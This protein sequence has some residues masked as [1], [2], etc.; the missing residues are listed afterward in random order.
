MSNPVPTQNIKRR[1]Y[2][3]FMSVPLFSRVFALPMPQE[4]TGQCTIRVHS[5]FVESLSTFLHCVLE[6]VPAVHYSPSELKD[7]SSE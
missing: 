3:K 2:C 1:I 5:I 6:H 4:V 7:D